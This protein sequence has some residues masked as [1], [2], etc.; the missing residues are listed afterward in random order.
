MAGG[1]RKREQ[2]LGH[3][4]QH[5]F[6]LAGLVSRMKCRELD[7]DAMVLRDVG[8]GRT[9]IQSRNRRRVGAVIAKRVG[10]GARG[11]AQH[12]EGIGIALA[13]IVATALHRF[14]DGAAQ[15]EL[16]AHLAH[17]GGNRGADHRFAQTSHHGAQRTFDAALAVF[18]HTA[19]QHQRP[20]RGI[21]EDRARS[22]GMSRPVVR[23]DLVADQVVHRLRVRHAQQRL[24]QT[25][26]RHA[27]L[28]GQAVF[29]QEHFHQ[30][31]IGS[32]AHRSHQIGRA[33]GDRGTL[34]RIEI[35]KGDETRQ[36]LFLVR[37]HVCT[38][39]RAQF[40]KL[41]R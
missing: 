21:D 34:F 32:T 12:V 10:L 36:R 9:R 19:G 15:H 2:T 33:H 39:C 5:R 3:D 1:Q 24:G 25:H 28:G 30:L 27:F 17:G 11:F 41:M 38:D 23:R 26:Q 20:G 16:L 29:G 18:Q 14:L 35:G 6:L 8:V 40:L 31:G 13:G 4:R 37:K 22:T 7:R